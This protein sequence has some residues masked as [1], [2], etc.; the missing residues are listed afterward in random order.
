MEKVKRYK[1]KDLLGIDFDKIQ[2]P[3]IREDFTAYLE[4][5]LMMLDY[6][7]SDMYHSEAINQVS[8]NHFDG[9]WLP[10]A[11]LR[12]DSDDNFTF[13]P[14][15]DLQVTPDMFPNMNIKSLSISGEVAS[16]SKFRFLN[17]KEKRN[18]QNWRYIFKHEYGFLDYSNRK[19]WTGSDGY[20]FN[21]I[22]KQGDSKIII[23]QN[24]SL[25]SGYVLNPYE[26]TDR[27]KQ[28]MK[29]LDSPYM[30]MLKHF[31]MSLQMSLTYYYEWSCYIKEYEDSIGVR[32]PI[33][34]SSSKEVFML[35]NLEKGAKRKKAI[36]NFVQSHQ[37]TVKGNGNERQVLVKKHLR[38]ELKFK[39]R[40]LEVHIIPSQYDLNRIKTKKNPLILD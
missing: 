36:C 3:K 17:H 34:P 15:G 29:D 40:G 18:L 22:T 32:I 16:V 24:T 21:N 30:T 31:H 9:A 20:G 12:H 11:S 2:K 7:S 39:W 13:S 38:G 10:V 26:V 5:A 35:R 25:K 4:N 19:W 14:F 27:I 8:L 1:N 33:H 23:P 28:E 6:K 37:R